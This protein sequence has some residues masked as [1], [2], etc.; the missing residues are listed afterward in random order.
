MLPHE[1]TG[2]TRAGAICVMAAGVLIPVATLL[3][4]PFV[5]PH[6]DAAAFSA[7]VT[8]RTY[9]AAALLFIVGILFQFFGAAS[10]YLLLARGRSPRVAFAGTLFTLLTD[11]LMLVGMGVFCFTLPEVGRLYRA[12]HHDAFSMAITF[13]VE[14]IAF[15]ALQALTLTAGAVLTALAIG[16]TPGL[17]RWCGVTYG[18]SAI[19]IAF[20]PPL[21][22]LTELPATALFGTTCFA[23]ARHMWRANGASAVPVRPT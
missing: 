5:D 9:M 20:S 3:R 6:A 4:G 17:P 13:S 11:A 7:W 10:L 22:F 12:G 14:F 8:G 18:T 1:T 19:L 2:S 15:Q 23:L 16:R 21:P